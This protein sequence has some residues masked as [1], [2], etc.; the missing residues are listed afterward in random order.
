MNTNT[1]P[2]AL[3]AIKYNPSDENFKSKISLEH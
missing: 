3:A 2:K 1:F